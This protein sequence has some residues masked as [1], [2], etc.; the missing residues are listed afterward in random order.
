MP[1]RTLTKEEQAEYDAWEK[2]QHELG[3]DAS[4]EEIEKWQKEATEEEEDDEILEEVFKEEP[5]PEENKEDIIRAKKEA[6]LDAILAQVNLT[7]FWADVLKNPAWS[8]VLKIWFKLNNGI[9]RGFYNSFTVKGILVGD[10][11]EWTYSFFDKDGKEVF[12]D[13]MNEAKV[14]E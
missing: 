1:V 5:I 14:A 8:D 10:K 2:R 6:I 9:V 3:L 12:F 4:D 13:I 11:I 7:P